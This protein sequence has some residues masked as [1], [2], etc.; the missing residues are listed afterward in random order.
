[1][2]QTAAFFKDVVI[3]ADLNPEELKRIAASLRRYD[4]E[5]GET[6]FG[7]GDVGGELF[8]VE[9]GCVGIRVRVEDGQ[10]LEIATMSRG[11]FFGEMSVF[12]KEPRSASC[13]ARTSCRLHSLHERDLNAIIKTAPEAA[14]KMMRRM[15]EDTRRRLGNTGEFLSDMVQWGESAHKR[16]ITDQLT[17]LYNRRYLDQTFPGL[18]D[19]ARNSGAAFALAIVD[20][21][22]FREINEAY[23]EEVG[24]RVIL[25][26]SEVFKRTLRDGDA[27][28]RYG[29]DEFAFVL[30]NTESQ[31]AVEIAESVRERVGKIDILRGLGGP[32]GRVTT[33]QGVA[34]FPLHGDDATSLRSAADAALYEAKEQGRDRVVLARSGG[35][36][37]APTVPCQT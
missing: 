5:E 26:V 35:V 20:L 2:G 18:V 15:L 21:D 23:S 11:E 14:A 4:L 29:G 19:H 1:M 17:G 25:A 8:I 30:P 16:A 36:P 12:E 9:S 27:A 7:E 3:L 22:R 31:T 28:I 13:V 34:C 33:S 6:L 24:D 37:E 10:E 32:V